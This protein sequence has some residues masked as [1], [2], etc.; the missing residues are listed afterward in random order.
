MKWR[1]TNSCLVIYSFCHQRRLYKTK[2]HASLSD[3]QIPH[4]VAM[5]CR[6]GCEKK[7]KSRKTLSLTAVGLWLIIIVITITVIQNRIV[8]LVCMCSPHRQR[9]PLLCVLFCCI[10]FF[11]SCLSCG[12]SWSVSVPSP[13]KTER[14]GLRMDAW[15][16]ECMSGRLRLKAKIFKFSF[17]SFFF[18]FTFP[19]F[20][21]L[22]PSISFSFQRL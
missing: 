15:R 20:H 1:P 7:K 4:D 8:S 10:Y 13:L 6:C 17:F 2:R 19:L 22:R 18:Y 3:D 21:L 12:E 5:Q 16:D 11:T 9:A 14:N